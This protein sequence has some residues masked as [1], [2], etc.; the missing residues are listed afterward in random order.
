MNC[1][2]SLR[3]ILLLLYIYSVQ[4]YQAHR[5]L[6]KYIS[7]FR[8]GDRTP[9]HRYA[10]ENLQFP[11]GEGAL[12]IN[13][14]IRAYKLGQLIQKE[15]EFPFDL[16][17]DNITVYSDIAPRCIDTANSLSLGIFSSVTSAQ[18]LHANLSTCIVC[19]PGHG[20]LRSSSDCLAQCMGAIDQQIPPVRF[21]PQII[22]G[23]QQKDNCPMFEEWYLYWKKTP[24]YKYAM[25]VIFKDAMKTLKRINNGSRILCDSMGECNKLKLKYIERCW[26]NLI[27]GIS[28]GQQYVKGYSN[29][30]LFSL[31]NPV[32]D[33]FW[34]GLYTNSQGP[35]IGGILLNFI[36]N[37]LQEYTHKQDLLFKG[38][39]KPVIFFSGHDHTIFSTLAAMGGVDGASLAHFCAHIT[40]AVFEKDGNFE[41]EIRYNQELFGVLGCPSGQC[42]VKDFVQSMMKYRVMKY[43][44]CNSPTQE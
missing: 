44:Q 4:S 7:I 39:Q 10:F 27:C 16:H 22:T 24:G 13:G 25:D 26:S 29:E 15:L 11:W 2:N 18:N 36:V 21:E 42:A 38:F 5:K 43:D 23:I 19:R 37:I 30:Q 35:V 3:K 1:N 32:A 8:H 12:T 17:P 9:T 41:L 31:F 20:V 34:R 28:E 33:Y 6:V 40:Y 14:M